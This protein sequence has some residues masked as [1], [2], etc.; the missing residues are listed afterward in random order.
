[1]VVLAGTVSADPVQRRMPS[2]D[3]VT[4]LRLSSRRSVCASSLSRSRRGSAVVSPDSSGDPAPIR[5]AFTQVSTPLTPVWLAAKTLELFPLL[6]PPT[7]H[8]PTR[9][10]DGTGPSEGSTPTR[11]SRRGQGASAIGAGGLRLWNPRG[12][13]PLTASSSRPRRTRDTGPEEEAARRE[14]HE[15]QRAGSRPEGTSRRRPSGGGCQR[16]ASEEESPRLAP[17]RLRWLVCLAMIGRLGA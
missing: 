9:L 16:S 7:V 5:R 14:E 8:G 13:E 1:V 2:G 3:E 6:S 4:E 10:P 17:R 15:Y 12:F 11:H